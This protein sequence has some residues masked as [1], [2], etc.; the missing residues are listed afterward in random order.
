MALTLP[1]LAPPKL[2][3]NKKQLPTIVLLVV[4][5]AAAAWFGWQ[6]FAENAAPPPPVRKPHA[7]TKAKPRAPV[8]PAPLTAEARAKLIGEVLAATGLKHELDQLPGRMLAGVRQYGEQQLKT[9]PALAKGIE[10][11]VAK[12]FTADGFNSRVDAA[13]TNNFDQRRLQALLNEF[14]AL[15]ARTMVAMEHASHSPEEFAAFERSASAKPPAPERAALIKRIDAAS[16]ASETAVDVA[17]TSMQA[18]AMGIVGED[19]GKTG[20]AA[21]AIEQRRAAS[22]GKIRDATL[23]NLAFS[24]DGASDAELE[25]Y[26]RIYENANSKWFYGLVHDALVEEAKSASTN[27]GNL[28][29]QLKLK[30]VKRLAV[31]RSG[32]KHG[33]D[34]RACLALPTDAAIIKCA[35]AYR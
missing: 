15:P 19:Q 28:I 5:L 11:A 7:V 1:K 2:K 24:F 21:Q 25:K 3:L 8:K 22:V 29:S 10:D 33:A 34:A 14:S 17:T 30:P 26:A 16:R 18:I 20:S 6:R 27:A 4:V 9:T 13:L 32:S 31:R 35:E 23:L 12:S